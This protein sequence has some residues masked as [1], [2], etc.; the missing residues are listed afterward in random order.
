MERVARIPEIHEN[1]GHPLGE[2]WAPI[3]QHR[4]HRRRLRELG[5]RKRRAVLTIVHNEAVLFDV[6]L[7]YYSRFFAPDDIYVIDHDSTDGS[8]SGGGFIRIPVSHDTFDNTWIVQTV[9]R[10]QHE[11]LERYDVVLF[12]DVDEIVTPTPEWGALDAYIDEFDEE[13]VNC[14]GYEV[15]HLRDREGPFDPSR[16]VME[17]RGYWYAH[18]AYDKPA[19]ASVPM[20]WKPGFHKR[21]DDGFNWDPDLRLIHLH[22]V[23]FDL[24]LARHRKWR[25][26]AWKDLDLA[27]G[28]GTHNRVTDEDADFERWFYEDSGFEDQG[29]HIVVEP[30]PP[31]WRGLF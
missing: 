13:Y 1:P 3:R 14:V 15:V 25:G 4:R 10:H 11:L 27:E 12:V 7:R 16:P 31:S 9:E 6:W 30:I 21:A 2:F 20:Q 29:I 26:C 22:R 19:L 24:C 8:T 18:D 28:W 17:Q 23:D 5:A